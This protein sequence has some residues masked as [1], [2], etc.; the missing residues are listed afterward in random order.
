MNGKSV[1]VC[2]TDKMHQIA[3]WI[4]YNHDVNLS[5]LTRAAFRNNELVMQVEKE[6]LKSYGT[7]YFRTTINLP[8][9]MNEDIKDIAAK[10]GMSRSA[11]VR[12]VLYRH[13]Q[14]YKP[15]INQ[16]VP[17]GRG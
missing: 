1:T 5:Q 16:S 2:L 13:M 15:D 12:A 14:T 3:E 6:S 8:A 17:V 4:Y 7:G 11:V 10:K 9:E